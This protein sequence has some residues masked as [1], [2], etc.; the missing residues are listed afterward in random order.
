MGTI[1]YFS[2]RAF[3]SELRTGSKVVKRALCYN[4]IHYGYVIV[5]RDIH[6]K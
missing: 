5:S 3:S 1:G 4:G 2:L 6:V